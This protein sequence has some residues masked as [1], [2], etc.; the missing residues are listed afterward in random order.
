[1]SIQSL[2]DTVA[3]R[4][5]IDQPLAEKLT[6]S[7]FSVLQHSTPEIGEKVFELLPD[8]KPLAE[9]HDVLATGSSGFLGVF[10]KLL[11]IS[12]QA[13]FQASRSPML[14]IRCF[15]IFVNAIQ[16]WWTN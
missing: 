8:A 7:V 14:E 4:V 1:M 13:A 9:S 11:P 2:V 3:N 5:N 16:I 12:A 10:S 6:G 15:Y